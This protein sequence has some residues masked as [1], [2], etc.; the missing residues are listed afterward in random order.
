M[1]FLAVNGAQIF[2]QAFGAETLN[3]APIVLIHGSTSTGA[4]DWAEVAPRLAERWRVL[5]PDCRG[6]GQSTNPNLSYSFF[7]MA[8]DVADFVRALGYERAHIIGHSNGGNVAL[9]TLMEHPEV[10]ASTV[11]QAANA[12]V[13]TDLLDREPPL[14]N[15]ERVAREA[16]DWRAEMMRLHGPTHGPDYWRIL[17]Q[18][19]LHATITE[20]SYTAEQ[21]ARVQRPTL[22]I[23]GEHDTVNN[24]GQH[25]QFIARHIPNAQLWLPPNTGHNVH[26]EI[27]D[28]WLQRVMAFLLACS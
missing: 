28:E 23:Q 13:S 3:S 5:V 12:Y 4:N 18:L 2:Y 21:L 11:L 26:L 10:V 7:E 9:V 27:P 19:T 25:A 1:P 8:A 6:H 17:L 15:P 24:V 22:A 14:F 20:P 16:P